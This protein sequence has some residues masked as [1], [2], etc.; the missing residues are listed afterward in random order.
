V[1]DVFGR[2][3]EGVDLHEAFEDDQ[4]YIV[5]LTPDVSFSFPGRDINKLRA[6]TDTN[7]AIKDYVGYLWAKK[8]EP[9]VV[10]LKTFQ[11]P[12]NFSR[13][14]GTWLPPMR[15][16]MGVTQDPGGK[17]HY[18][19]FTKIAGTVVPV[20]YYEGDNPGE[21]GDDQEDVPEVDISGTSIPSSV[22]AE[23]AC[24]VHNPASALLRGL[25]CS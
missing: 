10:K 18:F 11:D 5:S 8:E 25:P 13:Y 20:D 12:F 14:G 2:L 23:M 16:R 22:P 19:T 21:A 4:E 3:E 9:A 17:Q 7:R 24:S 1:V 6:S 15:V